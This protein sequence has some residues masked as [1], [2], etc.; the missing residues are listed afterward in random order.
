LQDVSDNSTKD[1]VPIDSGLRSIG[2]AVRIGFVPLID[3]APIIVAHEQGLFAEEGVDSKL[4]RQL[5][6]GNVRDKLAFAQLDMSHALLGQTIDSV[7][8]Q[9]APGGGVADRGGETIL[10]ACS[11]GTGGDAITLSR[12]L[13]RAGIRSATDLATYVKRQLKNNP[14]HRLQLG[15]VFGSSVHHYLL[16]LWLAS[17]GIEPDRDAKLCVLPPPQLPGHLRA[18]H[19]DGFCAG[20]PWNSIAQQENSGDVVALTTDIVANH[21]DKILA[22]RSEFAVSNPDVV[23]AMIRALVR[24][25]AFCEQPGNRAQLARLLS[26]SEY[27]DL[28][29]SAIVRSLELHGLINKNKQPA[30]SFV[31]AQ[32]RQLASHLE[33]LAKQMIRWSHLDHAIDLQALV[34]SCMG[35]ASF[36][37]IAS[38]SISSSSSDKVLSY[39]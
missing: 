33:W 2:R 5:G 14:S 18:G 3:A 24:A 25:S 16:R 12:R 9:I 8:A 34:S 20:E 27:L 15:H 7:V 35:P 17:G 29:P 39:A 10:A 13:T 38:N 21:P 26:K 11:M 23:R 6:W 22:V 37:R 28:E 19:I 36:S 32:S 30:R 31:I 4:H 1:S